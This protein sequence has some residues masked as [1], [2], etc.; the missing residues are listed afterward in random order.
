[1]IS[2][3]YTK[4]AYIIAALLYGMAFLFTATWNGAKA[5]GRHQTDQAPFEMFA[6]EIL[7]GIRATDAADI[8]AVGG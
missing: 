4:L 1:M 5:Q 7:S 8:P 6:E 3:K 2:N